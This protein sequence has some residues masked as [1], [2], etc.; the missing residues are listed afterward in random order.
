MNVFCCWG[1]ELS[2]INR[3]LVSVQWMYFFFI[4]GTM[5][6]TRITVLVKRTTFEFNFN[7]IPDKIRLQERF[8]RDATSWWWNIAAAIFPLDATPAAVNHIR[9]P[10]S[11]LM[12]LLSVPAVYWHKALLRTASSTP[13]HYFTSKICWNVS[14]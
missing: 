7:S 12:C 1:D 4:R 8:Q 5:R 14:Y 3:K 6:L 13:K 10:R 9:E 11:Q 2:L